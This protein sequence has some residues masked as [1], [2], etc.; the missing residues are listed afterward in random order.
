LRRGA[1]DYIA[2]PFEL[3]RL[4]RVLEVAHRYLSHMSANPRK[5]AAFRVSRLPAM[6]STS[7]SALQ[8]GFDAY[9]RKPINLDKF[10]TVAVALARR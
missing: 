1:F 10:C 6:S 3:A 4:K 8:P 7:R 5:S 9:M 2:K